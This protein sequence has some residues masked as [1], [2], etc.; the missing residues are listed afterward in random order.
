M[1]T[2]YRY[3][4][5]EVYGMEDL[6]KWVCLNKRSGATLGHA[7]F[8]EP[9]KQ[10]VMEFEPECVFNNTCLANIQHFLTQLNQGEYPGKE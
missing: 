4:R 2:T 10:W 9:W 6:K 1:K 7:I 8:Y 5:F 3:I